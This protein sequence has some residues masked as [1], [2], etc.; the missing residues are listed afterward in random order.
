SLAAAWLIARVLRCGSFTGHAVPDA[1]ST[2]E[3]TLRRVTSDQDRFALRGVSS[4]VSPFS[5]RLLFP[6]FLFFTSTRTAEVPAHDSFPGIPSL[7]ESTASG[8]SHH[9]SL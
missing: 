2:A 5:R 7:H 3:Q 8:A 4:S 6:S 9:V 1:V